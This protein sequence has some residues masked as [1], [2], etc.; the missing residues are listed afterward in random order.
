ML[1]KM[2]PLKMEMGKETHKRH[3]HDPGVTDPGRYRREVLSSLHL[4]CNSHPW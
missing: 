1:V 4:M 2:L 3:V